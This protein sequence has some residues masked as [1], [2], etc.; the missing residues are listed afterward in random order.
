MAHSFFSVIAFYLT[1]AA[2]SEARSPFA[3]RQFVPSSLPAPWTSQGC[4]IDSVNSRTLTGASFQSSCLT[5]ESCLSFC[6]ASGYTFAGV[7]FSRECYC[8]FSLPTTAVATS[9]DECN[10]ACTGNTAQSCGA[11]N[12]LNV[13]STGGSG[14][15]VPQN[16]GDNW[17]YQGC[18][19]DNVNT[20][21]LTVPYHIDGGA[22][23]AACASTC[24]SHGFVYAGL[25]FA[26]E[27]WCGNSIGS[28]SKA[29]D[30]DCNM[31]CK[32]NLSQFCG[33][34]NRLT[35]YHLDGSTGT[36]P[37]SD[38][39]QVCTSTNV[40]RFNPVAVFKVP[41][42]SGPTSLG[43]G[44]LDV[45]TIPHI[46]YGIFSTG[47]AGSWVFY[48]LLNGQ[49]LPK[50][51]IPFPAP[52]SLNLFAGDSPTFVSTQFPPPGYS[53]YCA[54][55][56]T[57]GPDLLA[58]G[59]RSDL[60]SLC[61]NTTAGGRLDVVWDAKPSHPHYVLSSCKAVNIQMTPA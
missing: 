43:I 18:Y 60:W 30:G 50:G 1:I 24:K 27:C 15:S 59:G 23:I 29:P 10:S 26:D 56:N 37:G 54:M 7:E 22:T 17:N 31:A 61:S 45:N 16:A 25:E 12:R 58:A 11:G 55:A 57:G 33:G 46:S 41:P 51:T 14:P 44:D 4:F 40:A 36:T 19:T 42:A 2:L 47:G 34:T 32:G 13:F 53:G 21:T 9:I 49:I 52:V 39:P 48:Q 6:S 20:R 3:R 28:A 5:V 38:P 8:G 35:L